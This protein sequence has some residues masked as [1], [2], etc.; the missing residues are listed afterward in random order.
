MFGT[1]TIISIKP[2]FQLVHNKL[3]TTLNIGYWA[4]SAKFENDYI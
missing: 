3:P 4:D 1:L 2:A